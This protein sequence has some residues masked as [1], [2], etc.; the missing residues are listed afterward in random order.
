MLKREMV[1]LSNPGML[2]SPRQN[3]ECVRL[4]HR[5]PPADQEILLDKAVASKAKGNSAFTSKPADHDGAI[6]LYQEALRCLP[7][8]PK[9]KDKATA[10]APPR[11]MGSGIQEVSEEEASAIEAEQQE[12]PAIDAAEQEREDVEEEIRECTKSCWGNLA[13]CHLAKVSSCPGYKR[14]FRLSIRVAIKPRQMR[15]R[16]VCIS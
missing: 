8:C 11:P 7:S 4:F 12:A 13:A 9:R 16:R 5:R 15:V 1:K 14:S 2:L 3:Y 10:N 6:E